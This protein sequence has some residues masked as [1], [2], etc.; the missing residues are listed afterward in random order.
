MEF[1]V[2][3][4]LEQ[5]KINKQKVVFIANKLRNSISILDDF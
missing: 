4:I 1:T 2:D 5:L 3:V